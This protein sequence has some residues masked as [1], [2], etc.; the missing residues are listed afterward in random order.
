MNQGA[1]TALLSLALKQLLLPRGKKNSG[2]DSSLARVL[3]AGL[4]YSTGTMKITPS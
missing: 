3:P 4:A 2:L 1:L